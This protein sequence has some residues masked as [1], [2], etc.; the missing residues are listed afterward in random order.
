[1]NLINGDWKLFYQLRAGDIRNVHHLCGHFLAYEKLKI[2]ADLKFVNAHGWICFKLCL[3]KTFVFIFV[4]WKKVYYI[5]SNIRTKINS[6]PELYLCPYLWTL[7]IAKVN[8]CSSVAAYI[9]RSSSFC[10][11]L[12]A[13]ARSIIRILNII[14]T[15]SH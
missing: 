12:F 1:M 15:V 4:A 10:V 5:V 6:G 2:S 14:R 9:D 3:F 13:L 8:R 7:I 11:N